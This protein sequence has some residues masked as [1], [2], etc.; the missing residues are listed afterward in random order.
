MKKTEKVEYVS[1]PD[2]DRPL[3]N[4]IQ[5]PKDLH[6]L[7]ESQLPLLAKE[8]RREI[9]DVVSKNGGHLGASLGVVEL[10]VALHYVFNAP[11]DKIIW[12]VGHQSYAHKLLTGRL[13]RF[14][15]LR[16]ENGLSGF[17][18]RSES[19]YDA[20]GT[21]HSSTSISAGVGMAAGRDLAGRDNHVIAVIGDGA[22]SA[23]MAYEALNNASEL[24]SRLIVVLNDNDM[25]I[26]K[27]V[28]GLSHHLSRLISSKPYLSFRQAALDMASRFP[29]FVK[30]TALT[31]ERHAKGVVTDGTLFEEL[32]CYYIGPIDGHDFDCL[33]PIFRNI[34][35]IR[36]NCPIL[37]HV[38]T[39]KGKGY[40]PA[41]EMP[42]RYH[43]VSGFDVET[44]AFEM[45]TTS[46]PAYT[47][48]FSRALIDLAERDAK[49][50]AVT[51]AMPSGVGLDAF[52]KRFPK[53]FFD[54]GIAEQHAVT[55]AAGMACEGLKPFVA[56]YS[57]FLQRSYDQIVHD[58]ALQN[59]PV[60]FA[61]DRAGFVGEDGATHHGVFDLSFLCPVPNM[62]VMAPSDQNELQRMLATMADINDAPSAIRYPRGAGPL[63]DVEKNL[64]PLPFG[65]GRVVREGK[66]AA[67]LSLGACLQN[68]VNAANALE[69][70]NVSV[71]VADAR[72]AKPFDTELVRNLVKEHSALLVVEEGVQGGFGASVLMWLADNGL[73]GK[74]KVRCLHAPDVFVEHAA[75]DR[76]VA[77]AGLDADS[78]AKAIKAVVKS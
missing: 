6:A 60:R 5:T 36:E 17:P 58:V 42:S 13:N 54:V 11:D 75:M 59:L 25:S 57:S 7:D 63:F 34:C 47:E 43:G 49:I 65:K 70:D 32:G 21:G 45:K 15:S 51:A 14:P 40:K 22:M 1:Q 33:I 66:H 16:R 30:N 73:L 76:Q 37:V 39:H 24:K 27:P 44:G 19:P 62:I 8:I 31:L 50:T 53:R 18:R 4:K 69:A 38:V 10:T 3:L 26:A 48:I 68:C 9:I 55:F 20:F 56:I 78:I 72:F 46:R 61:I 52:A 67:V 12:D 71:T 2:E 35:D 77:A 74:I 41:E 29:E 23:G 64:T 28:G